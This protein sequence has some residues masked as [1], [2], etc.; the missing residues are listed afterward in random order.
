MAHLS[1]DPHEP[2]DRRAALLA[3]L[4]ARPRCSRVDAQAA[5]TA[6]GLSE[7]QVFNLIRRLRA[8]RGD[9]AAL[10]PRR[11]NGGLGKPRLSQATEQV[12]YEA[13]ARSEPHTCMAGIVALIQNQCRVGGIPMPSISTIRRRLK[14]KRPN[15]RDFDTP[16]SRQQVNSSLIAGNRQNRQQT[17][18][19]ESDAILLGLLY[20][21]V[22]NPT[23]WHP[24]LDSLT[25]DSYFNRAALSL[26]DTALP[27][28]EIGAQV[29]IDDATVEAYARHYAAVNPWLARPAERPLGVVLTTEHVV[30][31]ADLLKTEYYHDFC[32]PQG[33]D[34]AVGLT[35]VEDGTRSMV[36]S[37]MGRRNDLERDRHIMGRLSRLAPH[38]VRVAQ[39][40][41]QL[42]TLETRTI[43]AEAA[44]DRLGTAVF[45]VNVT[46]HV[47][48]FNSAA[49]QI[50]AA[51]DGLSI[52]NKKLSAASLD[53]TETVLRLV[54][55]AIRASFSIET[56]PGGVIRINRPSGR[57][58]YEVLVA[59]LSYRALGHAFTG[60]LAVV[61][62]R[63]PEA[64]VVAPMDRLRCLYALTGAEARLAQALLAGDT[65]DVVG[66]RFGVGKE[67]LRSQLKS[68][69]L[70]TGTSSQIELI[71][72]GLRGLAT[73][74]G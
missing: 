39:L 12:L 2:R 7:R 61:F 40:N 31:H 11:S 32:R 51:R 23:G 17:A 24:F 38:L 29:N 69:F 53:E 59:P 30:P 33:I 9:P 50:I 35:V 36:V 64:Q 62:A 25:K 72:V 65:L 27:C 1:A 43:S 47:V 4:A 10:Q 16:T 73:F 46:G 42:V 70:K 57:M 6:L 63:D 3:P 74:H 67:T 58:P 14:S 21:T 68:V 52:I 19:G 28:G 44:L 66:E 56:T 15:H 48:H 54:A 34:L 71:R 49:Q 45:V 26:H 22:G 18:P 5:A 41:R 37:A 20:D 13:I 60:P 8:A 55:E